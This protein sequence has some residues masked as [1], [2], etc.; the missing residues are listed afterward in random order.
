M[1]SGRRIIMKSCG[2]LRWRW[3]RL[4]ALSYFLLLV[5]PTAGVQQR[6]V[7]AS[8]SNGNSSVTDDCT[9]CQ[10]YGQHFR[11]RVDLY[12]FQEIGEPHYK[13][14]GVSN[15]ARTKPRY[16][17][18]GISKTHIGHIYGTAKILAVIPAG[19]EI[20]VEA[21]THE[22]SVSSGETLGLIC[23]L[24]YE[25]KEEP[26]VGAEFI[27]VHAMLPDGR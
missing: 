19:S 3:I 23:R 9:Y 6:F 21:A 27:Q 8:S 10:L 13:Y 20:V 24:S 15:L 14:F 26:Q 7:F 4:S 1:I 18:I 2:R 5:L 17:P 25:G 11:T 22:V 12:L 16:L